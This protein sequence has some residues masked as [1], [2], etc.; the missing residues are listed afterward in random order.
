MNILESNNRRNTNIFI[1]KLIT[2]K[3]E[4]KSSKNSISSEFHLEYQK[5]K[6]PPNNHNK[7]N[8]EFK[9][10]VEFVKESNLYRDINGNKITKRGKLILTPFQKIRKINE[11]IKTYFE[12]RIHKKNSQLIIKNFK[13]EENQ[14]DFFN[15]NSKRRKII[16]IS[17]KKIN[18]TKNMNLNKYKENNFKTIDKL[19]LK[20]NINKEF[21][22][23]VKNKEKSRTL[24]S[25]IFLCLTNTPNNS[26]NKY[27]NDSEFNQVNFWKTKMIKFDSLNKTNYLEKRFPKSRNINFITEYNNKNKKKINNFFHKTINIKKIHPKKMWI[28]SKSIDEI[29]KDKYNYKL[30]QFN[31]H[32]LIKPSP[33]YKGKIILNTKRI[34]TDIKNNFKIN[35]KINENT[36]KEN[37]IIGVNMDVSES[38]V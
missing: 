10:L 24:N 30:F 23:I 33:K 20:N 22:P 15:F 4:I 1:D 36:K 26:R 35:K 32:Q 16:S 21:M 34:L 13:S 27:F 3:E 37:K 5:L 11:E 38:K 6:L 29:H 14:V 28:E 31:I 25:K 12:N 18:K 9:K 8:Q 17:K 2:E 7:F 19:N